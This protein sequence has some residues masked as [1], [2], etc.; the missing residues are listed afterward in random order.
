M[1][2]ITINDMGLSHRHDPTF[3]V[4]RPR[5]SGDYLLLH[6]RSPVRVRLRQGLVRVPAERCLLFSPDHPHWYTGDGVG[7]DNHWVHFAGPL[8]PKVVRRLR[9]PLNRP[10]HPPMLH[11]VPPALSEVQRE[12]TQRRP[13]WQ[14]ACSL[15]MQRVL[16]L[17]AREVSAGSPPGDARIAEVHDAL[18]ALRDRVAAAPE[19]EWSVAEMARSVHLSRSRFATLFTQWHGDSPM[20]W[21]IRAR[22]DRARWYLRS[23]RLPVKGVAEACGFRSVHYF[24]RAFRQRVGC[25]PSEYRDLV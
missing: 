8:A 22:V 2:H 6:F 10:F 4:D 24:S 11:Q 7:L 17:L 23:S 3:V 19:R 14:W 18:A 15:L 13:R 20:A 16:L 9:L 12:W 5:G 21:V 25:S 1:E